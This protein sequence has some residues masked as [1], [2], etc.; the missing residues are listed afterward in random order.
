MPTDTRNRLV[1]AAR[2]RFYRDGFRNVGIDAILDDVG[3]SKT[4]FYKHFESK[5]DL[6]IAVLDAVGGFIDQEFRR[7][8]K[9]RGGPSAAGQ[10]AALL[11]VVEHVIESKDFHGC[12][13]VNA[14]M[15]FPS[16]H[17]P[18]HQA[19]SRHKR[20]LEGFV[21]ELAERAR[22]RDPALLAQELCMVIEGAYVT[23]TVTGNPATI[24]IARRLADQSIARQRAR[25]SPIAS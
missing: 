18:I 17:D 2:Q 1:D 13:F 16:P 21:Y 23:R 6:M 22:A 9:D 5:D 11:D 8:V 20:A 4:A 14:A 10:L 12:I 19:A 25:R 3:I 24:L 7:M 15:E